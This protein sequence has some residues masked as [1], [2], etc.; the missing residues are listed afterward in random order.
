MKLIFCFVLSIFSCV[1]SSPALSSIIPALANQPTTTEQSISVLDI[2]YVYIIINFISLYI[3]LICS[4]GKAIYTVLLIINSLLISLNAIVPT[5]VIIE[6]NNQ[7]NTAIDALANHCPGLLA[8]LKAD[9][10]N[11]NPTSTTTPLPPFVLPIMQSN[12]SYDLIYLAYFYTYIS[13]LIAYNSV[14]VF[15]QAIY[16]FQKLSITISDVAE[17]RAAFVIIMNKCPTVLNQISTDLNE[18]SS[19]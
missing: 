10:T 3:Y 2:D 9:S 12:V 6:F 14:S 1:S 8:A 5:A 15:D 7:I 17:I 11:Q 13:C 19:N 18:T 4:L 16:V